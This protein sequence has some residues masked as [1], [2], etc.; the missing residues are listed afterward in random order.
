MGA[1]MPDAPHLAP[2]LAAIER[3]ALD[4][5]M[6][7]RVPQAAPLAREL[8]RRLGVELQPARRVRTAGRVRSTGR[9]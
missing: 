7:A 4:V 6:E 2:L 8:I 3:T 5:L 1:T 9:R